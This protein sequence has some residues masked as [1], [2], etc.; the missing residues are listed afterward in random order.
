MKPAPHTLI[1]DIGKTNK[2]AYVFDEAFEVVHEQSRAFAETTDDD[3]FPADD[4][5]AIEAWID[6]TTAD[7]CRRLAIGQVNFS[8]YGATLVHLDRDG[9]PTTP[10]YNYL[11]PVDTGFLRPIYRRFGGMRHLHAVLGSP[12]LGMLNSGW[13]LAWLRAERPTA[14]AKTKVTLHF[15]QYLAHRLTGEPRSEYTSVGCHTALW[16][17]PRGRYHDWTR[18]DGYAERLPPV[19]HAGQATTV[20][21]HGRAVRVGVGIHDS[22]AAL[23]PYLRRHEAPFV[24]LSTGTWSIA[25]NAWNHSPLTTY[26][27]SR[28]CLTFMRVDGRPVKATRLFLGREHDVRVTELS[29]H[30]GVH[31]DTYKLV[32]Y[33]RE[34][35]PA[36]EPPRF[37]W[38]E[39]ADFVERGSGRHLDDAHFQAAY[40]RLMREL[41]DVQLAALALV[42]DDLRHLIVDGGL[43][44]SELLLAM[45]R[46]AYPGAVVEAS[47][48]PVGSALG[49]ALVLQPAAVRNAG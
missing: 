34:L 27:L 42:A 45:L 44:R 40:H 36:S 1:F 23:V 35:D 20:E 22:S 19:G 15:P 4:L 31:P 21:L 38:T 14:F 28:D 32:R 25:L 18:A 24:L 30:Y 13:Q 41:V 46:R 12:P 29:E 47:A 48:N 17:F 2:K 26:E 16:D 5:A 7:L 49:A 6:E 3:D 43:A 11:K 39:L 37:A 33:R 9:A 8:T 10:L